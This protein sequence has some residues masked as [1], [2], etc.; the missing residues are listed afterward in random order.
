M[1]FTL[2]TSFA[3][4]L[5][6]CARVYVDVGLNIG[7]NLRTLYE[8]SVASKAP[9]LNR[10]LGSLFG[11]V[12]A[13]QDVCAVGIEPNPT[14]AKPLAAIQQRLKA[15][16]HN[17]QLFGLAVSNVSG[18]ATYWT[19][20]A[21]HNNVRNGWGN[22]LLRWA[23]NMDDAHAVD[24]PTIPLVNVLATLFPH[25]SGERP[26]TL[27]VGLKIDC[28]GC[29]YDSVPQAID[30]LC[31]SVDVMWLERHDRFFST[32]WRGHKAGFRS[33]GRREALD[34]SIAEMKQRAGCRVRVRN[35]SAIEGAHQG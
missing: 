28:E 22:S 17:V 3:P 12:E 4:S 7:D 31:S 11:S 35:L 2:S 23:T 29:E 8:P 10:T 1:T 24:V 9:K 25:T 21:A 5:A 34:A 18:T 16:G 6:G 26:R 30:A 32:K 20:T 14:H 19:D 15:R 27:V 33:E 13:R